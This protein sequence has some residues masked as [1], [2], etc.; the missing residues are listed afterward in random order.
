[1]RQDVAEVEAHAAAEV[2]AQARKRERVNEREIEFRERE[3][4]REKR[5]SGYGNQRVCVAQWAC[6]VHVAGHSRILYMLA[7]APEFHGLYLGLRGRVSGSFSGRS[8][9]RS[10]DP[11]FPLCQRG[12][13]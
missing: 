4:E 7:D 12:V 3:R 2:E 9:A 8:Q 13:I 10:L 6:P 11:W 1:M 5:E